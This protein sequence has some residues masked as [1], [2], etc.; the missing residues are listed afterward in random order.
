MNVIFL[1]VDGVFYSTLVITNS[2]YRLSEV[3]VDTGIKLL[4][5][6]NTHKNK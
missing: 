1:D 6:F 2:Y 3:N 4:K 5:K